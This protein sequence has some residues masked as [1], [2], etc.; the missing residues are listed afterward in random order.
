MEDSGVI[1]CQISVYKDMLDQ[2][3]REIESEIVKCSELESNLS[4]KEAELT[5]S[6]LAS[7]FEISGLISVTADSRNSLKLLEDEICRLRSEHCQ[8][9]RRITEKREGFVKMC[10]E[11]QRDIFVDGDNELRSL[12]SEREFL[13]NEVRMLK[14]KNA[15]VKNSILAYME[16]E[17]WNQMSD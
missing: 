13:E 6:F 15:T 10:F 16:D 3:T 17:M 9:L 5:R 4:V 11:F 8:L 7:Q 12:L 14:E 2:V 1:L